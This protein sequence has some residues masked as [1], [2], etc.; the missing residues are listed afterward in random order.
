MIHMMRH[1]VNLLTLIVVISSVGLA[2]ALLPPPGLGHSQL[3]ANQ[4]QSTSSQKSPAAALGV[5]AY[6][7]NNQNKEQQ[8]KDEG[9]CYK[10]AKDETGIDPTAPIQASAPQAQKGGAVKGAARGAVT[11]TAVGAIAGDTGKGAAI[12][13]T[14][15]A[16]RGRRQQKKANVEAQ[17]QAQANAQAQQ[18]QNLDKFRKAFSA[19]MEARQYSVK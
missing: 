15:G 14:A 6:P 18:Q 12:G 5:Y 7:K 3:A 13:A 1:S 8:G 10:W 2:L 9:K 17:N 19:C 16:V 4:A 11:G